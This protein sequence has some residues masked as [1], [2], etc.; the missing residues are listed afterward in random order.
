MWAKLQ[1]ASSPSIYPYYDAS[2]PFH[3]KPCHNWADR[4]AFFGISS[5]KLPLDYAD[6]TAILD[7]KKANK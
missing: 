4:L 5:L 2:M 6:A 7:L 1:S 3:L